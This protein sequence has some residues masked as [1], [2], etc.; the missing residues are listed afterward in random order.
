MG[1]GRRSS[2]RRITALTPTELAGPVRGS[3]FVKTKFSPDGT[4]VRGTLSNCASGAT[5]WN[6]YLAAEENWAL[7]FRNDDSKDGKPDQPRE[8]SQ[9]RVPRGKTCYHWELADTGD[10]AFVRFDA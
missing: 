4:S 2:H 1:G 5:P 9:Y 3:N 6:T 7:Y 8:H 10:D